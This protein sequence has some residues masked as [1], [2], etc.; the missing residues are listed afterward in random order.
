MS[1]EC[2]CLANYTGQDCELPLPPV[3]STTAGPITLTD[4]DITPGEIVG[5]VIG[6]IAVALIIIAV[7]VLVILICWNNIFLCHKTRQVRLKISPS[8]PFEMSEA[9]NKSVQELECPVTPPPSYDQIQP[10]VLPEII[11]TTETLP[12]KENLTNPL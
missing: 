9:Q 6:G 12:D 2:H 8:S 1:G 11:V 3:Q 4:P 7:V 10:C 5:V